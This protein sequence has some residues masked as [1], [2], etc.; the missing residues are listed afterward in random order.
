MDLEPLLATDSLGRLALA[1][2]I[3]GNDEGAKQ[4]AIE[5]CN[6]YYHRPV[7]RCILSTVCRVIEGKLPRPKTL[8]ELPDGT[9]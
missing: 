3:A 7:N 9:T 2:L 8:L 5:S 4:A 6:E 1:E